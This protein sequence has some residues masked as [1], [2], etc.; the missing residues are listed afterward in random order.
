LEKD[1]GACVDCGNLGLCGSLKSLKNLRNFK[2]FFIF[3]DFLCLH[4]GL[5][6]VYSHF[7]EGSKDG[8]SLK[9]V[10]GFVGFNRPRYCFLAVLGTE[11]L[12]FLGS[13]CCCSS[14]GRARPW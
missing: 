6:C 9:F 1:G 8:E 14:V 13:K 11:G 7:I 5:R 12:V 3:L 10:G 2:F 4:S